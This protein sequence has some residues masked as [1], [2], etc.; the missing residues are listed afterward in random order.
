[1]NALLQHPWLSGRKYVLGALIMLALLNQ[2]VFSFPWFVF[3]AF[4]MSLWL[5]KP[6]IR[7][8]SRR[9]RLVLAAVWLLGIMNAE[10]ATRSIALIGTVLALLLVW[11]L[12]CLI[13]H[14]RRAL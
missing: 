11:L 12:R 13:I 14:A 10:P 9:L 7:H 5:R 6:F 2:W 4:S 8:L 1:M 3:V